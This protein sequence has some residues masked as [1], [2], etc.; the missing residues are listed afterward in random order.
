MPNIIKQIITNGNIIKM[1]VKS[2]E[3]GPKGE[4]GDPGDTATIAAG[5]AYSV[6]SS[7]QPSVMNTGTSSAAVFDF[8]IPKGEKG[9]KGDPGENGRNGANGRDGQNGRDGKD[10]A[11]Q[12]T[13]GT[14][15]S[16]TGNVISAT[17]GGG[18]SYTAGDGIVIANNEISVD[19]AQTTG[20]STTKVMSQDAVT[21]ALASAGPTV[22]QTTGT[23]QTDVMSQNATTSMVY[24]DPAT[25]NNIKIGSNSSTLVPQG[26]VTVGER[27]S[28]RG[29]SVAI[30]SQASAGSTD[31][32]AIGAQA[33]L[34]ST[35]CVAIGKSAYGGNR[36]GSTAIGSN[37]SVGA[38]HPGS[39]A[40]GSYASCTRG[41]EVYIGTTNTDY[42]YNSTNY[43]VIG[44]VHD[45]VDAHDAA[46]KGYVDANAGGPT[47]VQ[48]SGTSTTDVMSQ[49]AT[50]SMVFDDPAG[51]T[52]VKIGYLS[53]STGAYSTAIGNDAQAKGNYSI[54]IGYST[55]APQAYSSGIAIGRGATTA[56]SN[57]IALGSFANAQRTGEMNIG[58]P[59]NLGNGYNGT[60]YRLLTG[61]HDPVGAHD[62]ATK[63]Y[64]D[65][66]TPVI[67]MTTTD[68]GEGS[69]LAANTFIAVYNAS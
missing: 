37:A 16:I 9:E 14:G 48:T 12:Y 42:G 5:Q 55:R 58:T 46:T 56:A 60:D 10:G 61:V 38:V 53:Q 54:G 34:G 24:D 2:N 6:P 47:V 29:N 17:G 39:V 33:S 59:N 1:I 26:S 7:Q 41:G 62:A 25:R 30:G 28:C 36:S 68:P 57:T 18:S 50:S 45:P 66:A 65:A 69:P 15:I 40:L 8:Y 51:Q 49:N 43:R 63:G 35:N 19:L 64:V 4:K 11:I 20:T 27:A 22:V 32:I 67:T 31:S 23:S 3:R 13:A 52:K 44:G 21:M